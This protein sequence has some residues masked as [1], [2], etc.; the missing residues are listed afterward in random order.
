[1]IGL[2]D[3]TLPNQPNR[4]RVELGQTL[5]TAGVN[6]EL[7]PCEILQ[8]LKRHELG[9]WG[10]LEPEDREA[11]EEALKN[12]DRLVSLYESEKGI[13]FY[14]ITEADRSATTVLL[15]KEY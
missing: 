10:D 14:V 6:E 11:N 15:R 3:G 13:R 4:P 5:M 1:M 2:E 9:D 8:A 12:G 7:E